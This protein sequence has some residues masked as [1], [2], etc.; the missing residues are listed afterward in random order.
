MTQRVYNFSAGPAVMPV[1]VLE[2]ARENMLSLGETG[3]GV[4]EHSHRGKPFV[5]V[6]EEA[7]AN[8]RKLANIPEDYDVLFLQGGASSQFFMIPQ[9]FLEKGKAADYLVTGSWSKKA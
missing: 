8:C 6:A 4:M 3:I 5:A 2:E 7:E 1:E 9:N